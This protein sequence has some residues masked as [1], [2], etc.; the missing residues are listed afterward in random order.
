MAPDVVEVAPQP[1]LGAIDAYELPPRV[2][3]LQA[4]VEQ[5]PMACERLQ[6]GVFRI[7]LRRLRRMGEQLELLLVAGHASF[8]EV[9]RARQ[10]THPIGGLDEPQLRVEGPGIAADGHPH[11][12]TEF[13]AERQQR[14]RVGHTLGARGHLQ[15]RAWR[16]LQ[17][18]AE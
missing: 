3:L 13:I 8:G 9:P 6:A 12:R 7:D 11:L 15:R 10:H 4:L 18:L 5:H 2:A 1:L 17:Q 16:S 14:H